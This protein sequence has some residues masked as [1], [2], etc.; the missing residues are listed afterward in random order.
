MPTQVTIENRNKKKVVFSPGCCDVV[1]LS[2]QDALVRILIRMMNIGI[3]VG[4]AKL[5]F[6]SSVSNIRVV[7]LNLSSVSSVYIFL[8]EVLFIAFILQLKLCNP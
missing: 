6:M 4:G 7:E 2:G 8:K 5:F 3:N 1:F